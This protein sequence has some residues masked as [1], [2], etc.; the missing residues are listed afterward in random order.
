MTHDT[1]CLDRLANAEAATRA[2]GFDALI[3]PGRGVISHYGYLQFLAGYCP[4]IRMGAV[5]VQPGHAPSLILTSE[6][7]CALASGLSPIADIR[8]G[9]LDG[10]A[11]SAGS[12]AAVLRERLAGKP[13]PVIAVA[14]LEEI[15]TPQMIEALAGVA[16]GARIVSGTALMQAVKLIKTDGD[17]RGLRAS[18][19]LADDAL[20]ALVDALAEPDCTL[21]EAAAAA[22]RSLYAN[23]ANE[24]LIYA[25]KGPHYLHRP[26]AERL[27]D[28]ELLTVFVECST[29]DGYWI[30]LARLI[31]RGTPDSARA[32]LVA[33]GELIMA[34]AQEAMTPGRTGGEVYQ[35]LAA[36]IAARGYR[37]GLWLGHGVGVDH[38][39]PTI[40]DGD[41]TVLAPQMSIAFHPHLVDAESG[42][43][44]SYGDTFLVT[45]G[46][47]EPL[48]RWPRDLIAV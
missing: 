34:A 12:L 13:D 17:V 24:I 46:S 43:G 21:R 4:V 39:L 14:G 29:T 30:E 25:S 37:S 31:A 23:G 7:D 32:R 9:S 40:G 38:D 10:P 16:P 11:G 35:D 22:S 3:A 8:L 5:V 27:E 19:A 1:P 26:R 33:D 45:A 47:A 48:S 36:M 41:Q 42:L 15:V 6:S 20:K 2:A 44:A 28:G 18:A